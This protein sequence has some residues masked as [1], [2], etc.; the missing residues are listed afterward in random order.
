VPYDGDPNEEFW[1][2]VDIDR[3]KKDV[4]FVIKEHYLNTSR[5]KK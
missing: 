4:Y 3:N 1:G 2:I 5:I